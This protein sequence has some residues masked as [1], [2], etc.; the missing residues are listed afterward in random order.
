[1]LARGRGHVVNIASGAGNM[2][3][4][5]AAP[6]SATKFALVGATQA[7]RAEYRNAPVGFSAICPGFIRDEGLYAAHEADGAVAPR[8]AG[9]AAPEKVARAVVRAIIHDRSEILVN[10]SPMRPLILLNAAFPR[11]HSFLFS[12]TGITGWGERAATPSS[13]TQATDAALQGTRTTSATKV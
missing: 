4:P 2:A 1:M 6:Y 7:L 8:I 11:A 5:S 13:D 3:L 10:S 9:P 12:R